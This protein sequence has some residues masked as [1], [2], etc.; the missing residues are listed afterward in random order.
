M[1]DPNARLGSMPSAVLTGRGSGSGAPGP[2]LQAASGGA[3]LLQRR[4]SLG[5]QSGSPTAA[6]GKHADVY[7]TELLSYSLDRLRKEPELLAEERRQLE[8]ALQGSALAHYPALIDGAGCLAS[9]RDSLAEALA[10]LEALQEDAPKLGSTC[11]AFSKDAADVLAQRAA[12]K[13]LLAQQ[14]TLLELL[15]APQLMDTCVRNGIYDEA[16]DLAAF[17]N[18]LGLLHP[19][20]PVVQLLQRQAGDVSASMLAQLLQRLRGSIQVR[21]DCG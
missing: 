8:R 1:M 12:N 9:V 13:Q 14:A 10:R 11:E 17:I 5:L 20:L 4:S 6:A 16:L 19:E 7:L 15:E 3:A 18:R 2:L 21:R